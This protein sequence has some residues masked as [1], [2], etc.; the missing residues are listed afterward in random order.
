M[1][2]DRNSHSAK[3][4]AATALVLLVTASLDRASAFETTLASNPPARCAGYGD[5]SSIS[6]TDWEA[7][8]GLWTVGRYGVV[9][10]VTFDTL[11]WAVAESLPDGRAGMAA[12]VADL[13]SGACGDDDET[14]VLTLLSPPIV[15]PGGTQV[16]RISI[17]HW[18]ETEPGW[19]GGNF[20]IK[21]GGSPFKLIPASAIE[22]APYNS[23]LFPALDE[24]GDPFNTNPLAGKDAFTRTIDGQP[25][26]SWIQ[27]RINLLGIAGAGATIQLRIDFGVDNCT[28]AVIDPPFPIGWY[29]DEVE[30]YNCEA[31]LPPSNC[32]N[33]VINGGEQCDD[34]N[35]FIGDGCSNTCQIE[36][37]WQC[38]EPT[39][40]SDVP[41]PSFEAG[42]PNPTWNE[43]S[44]NFIGTPICEVAVC[45]T[46]GGTGPSDGRFW[47]WFGGTR[48]PDH[49][50]SVSQSLVI[51]LTATDLTFG[52]ETSICDSASDYVEVLIDGNQELIIDGSSPLCGN[53]GYSTQSVD[54]RAYADGEPHTLEFHSET[55]SNN[56]TFTNFFIDVI[57]L[58]GSPS[59]CRREGTSLTLVKDVIN[60]DGGNAFASA[61]TLTATGP[62]P[63]SGTGPT[64]FSG[65]GFSA[66]TYNLAESGGPAGYTASAWV[67]VGGTQN[68]NTIT[69]ALGEAVTCTIT[70][71]DIAPTLTVAKTILNDSGGSVTDP[72]A[73]GLKVDG[74]AVLHNNPNPVD[75]GDHIVSE[76][77]LAD[78][79]PG[80]WGGDC[81]ADGSIVL[82]LGEAATC[83][84]TNDDITPTLTVVKTI[85]NDNIGT[86]T[87][88]N[89]FGLRVDG[90]SVQHNVATA[91]DAGNHTVSEVGLAGYA[92]GTWGGD[93]NADGTI[94]L[95]LRQN[96]TCTITND[97]TS[98]LTVVK[99][100]I[101]NNSGTVTDPNAFGLRVDGGSVQH[102]V[103]N[104]FD[105]GNH[106]VSEDG[107]PGYVP[108][109]WGG[110]CNA[111][112]TITL[113]PNQDATCTVTND[114][115]STLTVFK[116]I[117]N[118]SGGTVTNPNAFGLRVDGGSVQHNVANPFDA[119]S[120]TVSEDGLQ[121]Y[122]PGTWGGD[123]NANGTIT[124]APNQDAT[125]TITNDDA[126][127]LTVVKTIINNNGGTTT[128]HNAFGLRVDG[129]SVL[130]NASNPF[131]TGNHTV[132]EDGLPGYMPG[133][134]G[135]DCNPDGTITLALNQDAICTITNDD[136]TPTLTVVK[137]IINDNSG[138]VTN[139]NAFGLRVDGGNV[140][141]NASNPFNA[142]N[143]TV[144]EDGLADYVAGTW[145]GD[146]NAD[147]T[148]T[149]AL[150]Q[151]ATCTITN[152]DVPTLTVVKT[153]I[154][155][156]GGTITNPNA[157][158]LKVDGGVV[159]HGV[160][161]TFTPGAHTVSE[162]GL[163]GYQPG[164][165]GG[166]CNTN[167]TIT[168]ALDQDAICTITNDDITPH[169]TMVKQVINNNGGSAPAS[170]W[171]L[172]AVG[173]TPF[174]GTG[175]FVFSDPGFD[176]GTYDLSESGG[177]AGYTAS[178]WVCAGGTQNGNSITLALGGAA[179]CTIINND[180]T[181]TLTVAK[182]IIND[183]DG[184]VTDP[185]A[186]GLKVDD[187]SVLHNE[188][189]AFDVGNHTVSEDGLAGYVPGTWGGDCN[190][191]GT[192]TLALDQDAT[193]TITN[194][195]SVSTSLT[196]VKQ[197]INNNGGTA[198]GSAWTLSAAGPTPFSGAG[199]NVSNDPGFA[200]GTY[201]LSE[202][203][204]PAGYTASAWVCVGGTQNGNSITLELG[205][206]ATCTITNNDIT[207][208]LTVVKTIVN[209][210]GGT[211]TDENA[212]GLKVDGG[213]V[214]HGVSNPF[215]AGA[216][217]VTEDGLP[218][219]VA[220][221]WGGD[222]A[223]DPSPWCWVNPLPAPS[224]TTTP[225]PPA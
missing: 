2:Q 167:G 38:A 124:L 63:F 206:A 68:G 49:E 170:A 107:L 212:F 3:L 66:G 199:P 191:D 178:A 125:C 200:P 96:A 59:I 219:Y 76:A 180:I 81:N 196:L 44:N 100:I 77:G 222:C 109:I 85:I 53:L 173:P 156:N 18:F 201:D 61:W 19:D 211:I 162:D 197:V 23:T 108:G 159:L 203:G 55:F 82:A 25:T 202:S 36:D 101:N 175:P 194:D 15:I 198:S 153:I 35:D 177:P 56:G 5:L 21:V 195:D 89:A 57:E 72:N 34:G 103:A 80:T 119:G 116:T 74:F 130:H 33:G 210:N 64:V 16:P 9:N 193:C 105:A 215:D 152:D 60:D 4:L 8:L 22:I 17:D 27:S 58:P 73:F 184:T 118:D 150:G 121:G 31:E 155:D 1:L 174:S 133:T 147:G 48:Q 172:S 92:P 141:N 70:N 45:G 37:G 176:A 186:F 13:V 62:T 129:I 114:D 224:P 54:I 87:D 138:T 216:H 29:V 166:D 46:S 136:I 179:T 220:G 217:T 169:L 221:T 91:F 111:N 205:E 165:W 26:G 188:I 28:P 218:G 137:N 93:C 223:A 204:G 112:G 6:L 86:V 10:E 131:N 148:I 123:C 143:H 144:S 71:E 168:L 214:L 104:A 127:T 192:I 145:G 97:D 113:A 185:N 40:P 146:C 154:N 110:D 88:P 115:T 126:P 69:L 99:T 128:N 189:N 7:G 142:G 83:T 52:F 102:N 213:V 135:G 94:T 207:P 20:R 132:S 160:S 79:I 65:E 78:Y 50:G 158:G 32:G 51:P 140:L 95:A 164:T 24:L 139:P 182:T 12:F 122:I 225:T 43:A 14:G 30:F 98:T 163:A 90:G 42:T 106:T 67:C 209:N 47:V 39:D 208:S 161:N 171:T 134:W 149:L 181:P 187:R 11:D 41:D 183:N 120:H 75:V 84:I 151:N 157:F 190:P 117:V